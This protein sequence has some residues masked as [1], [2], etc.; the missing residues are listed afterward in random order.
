MSSLLRRLQRDSYLVSR[1][2]GDLN[3]AQRGPGVLLKRVVRRQVTRRVAGPVWG[4][5]WK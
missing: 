3:A 1:T 4:R 5:L 2:A